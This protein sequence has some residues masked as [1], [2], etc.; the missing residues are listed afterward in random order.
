MKTLYKKD[1]KGKTRV[2]TIKTDGSALIQ[3][4]G[5]L[6]GKKVKHTK[7]C[8]SKNIGKSNQT[9]PT[10][11]A[12]LELESEYKAKLDEGYFPTLE[13]VKTE[14]VILPMLA[15][16]YGDYAHK[17]DWSNAYVQPKLD[18]MRCLA[19]IKDGVVT[20]KSRDGKEI[21][22]MDHIKKSL[23][24]CK[25]NILDGELYAHGQTFQ[26]NMR[27]IK[28][29][30][31]GETENIKYHVYDI[32]ESINFTVRNSMLEPIFKKTDNNIV[33]VK[34]ILIKSEEELKKHH[35]KFLNEGYEGSI[36]RHGSENYK[37]G[38]R[39]DKL[40]KYKDFHDMSLKIID[41]EPAE[42]RPEQ[43][44]LVCKLPNGLICRASLK[45]SHKERE[46]I[47]KNKKDYIGKQTAEIRYFEK[48]DDG[49]LR[50]PVCVGFRLD[51]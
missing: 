1:S 47:L 42:Q 39:S 7:V 14:E 4:A 45:F 48:T 2:W 26:E 44:V 29:Y 31:P 37:T 33:S 18:G 19:I 43:G 50:F 21:Q 51:K 5:L 20:L 38:G 40:L 22:N 35:A 16:S 46:E 49:N 11:Q 28:K 30:R 27:L 10:E 24:K 8:S 25:N 23:S 41:I 12:K 36:L 32:I 9:T 15:K 34:T 6:D 3:E 13:E 17:I